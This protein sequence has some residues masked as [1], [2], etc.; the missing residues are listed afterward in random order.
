MLRLGFI[1]SGYNLE[2]MEVLKQRP[3][4]RIAAI[5]S[6]DIKNAKKAV[7]Q[8]GGVPYDDYRK[9]LEQEQI[10]AA[11]IGL[12][13]YLHGEPEL[14]CIRKKVPMFIEKPV[15][16]DVVTAERIRKAA[17]RKGVFLFVGYKYRYSPLVQ[18]LA[19]ILKNEKVLYFDGYF[20]MDEVPG[21]KWWRT[22]SMS[23]GQMVEQATHLVDLA[24]FFFGEVTDRKLVTATVNLKDLDI[25]DSSALL[26]KCCGGAIGCIHC[27]FAGSVSEAG[28]T[29]C[30]ATKRIVLTTAKPKV[31]LLIESRRG[32]REFQEDERECRREESRLFL[33]TVKSGHGR[34]L[35]NNYR[36]AILTLKATL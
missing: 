19:D 11:Y 2:H 22:R 17:E 14:L 30:T 13:P 1:G 29:V 5:F 34:L 31:K 18:K 6:R 27:S 23:G 9:M 36:D 21:K 8:Y 16:L 24:R 33:N 15:A 7:K 26:V 10:D 32:R 35:E 12:P 28:L 25:P 4:V 20:N 3:D